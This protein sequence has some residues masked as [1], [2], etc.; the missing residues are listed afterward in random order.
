M[1]RAL[2]K[3]LTQPEPPKEPFVD[4]VLGQF[5][6]ERDLGWKKEIML[7]GKTAEL[8]IGS[9]GGAPSEAMLQT[10]RSWVSAWPTQFPKVIEYMRTELRKW[11][12]EPNLPNPEKF[13]VESINVLWDD[14]PGASMIYF[15]YPGDDIRLWHVTLYGLEAHGFAYDD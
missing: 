5:V 4:P 15:N 8:I 3:F 11:A 12:D 13:E 10:A 6:F 7:L 1:F 9:D 2:T 14:K